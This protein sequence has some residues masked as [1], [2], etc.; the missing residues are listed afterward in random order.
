MGVGKE[1]PLLGLRV[2]SMSVSHFNENL[3]HWEAVGRV[4]FGN[5]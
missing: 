3:R 5:G 1:E 2:G 4:G